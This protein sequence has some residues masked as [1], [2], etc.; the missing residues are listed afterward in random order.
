MRFKRMVRAL[1]KI[2]G[3]T[4]SFGGLKAVRDVCLE[5]REGEIVGLIGPNGAGKSTFFN[6]VTGI[7]KPDQGTIYFE[8]KPIH[9]LKPHKIAN[10]GI[11]RT[12]QNIRLLKEE[13]VLE[14][15]K[16]GMFR[17]SSYG[18]W[19]TILGLDSA[20]REEEL[21]TEKS[22]QMIQLVGLAGLEDES[23]GN[24]SYGNQRRVEIARALVSN[25]KLLLLDEPIA[26]MNAEEIKEMD[27]LIRLIRRENGTTVII[28]EHNVGMV[29]GLCDRVAVLDHGEK[30]ADDKPEAITSNPTVIEAYI[31]KEDS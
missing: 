20:K 29:V 31:G 2:D 30:I 5:V 9:G 24:L 28:I 22:K 14:N 18:L 26:G 27:E 3:I 17:Q 21:V 15:V 1:L 25:P 13:T 16:V 12:F 19:A 7:Y 6:M 8:G 4:K 23:A 11:F 10:L